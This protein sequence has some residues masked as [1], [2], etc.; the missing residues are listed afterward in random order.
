MVR[1]KGKQVFIF[2]AT[3]L[4]PAKLLGS[5]I[6]E[7]GRQHW[8]NRTAP[9]TSTYITRFPR[10]EVTKHSSGIARN[11]SADIDVNSLLQIFCPFSENE[12][13]AASTHEPIPTVMAAGSADRPNPRKCFKATHKCHMYIQKETVT[14]AGTT[15]MSGFVGMIAND[16]VRV[17]SQHDGLLE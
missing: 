3:R 6:L 11:L 13:T 1:A 17:T 12:K 5:L 4:S 16:K 10:K 14:N 2:L 7:P 9:L 15:G 8:L